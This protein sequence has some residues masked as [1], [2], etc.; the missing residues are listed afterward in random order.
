[1]KQFPCV[2]IA[3]FFFGCGGGNFVLFGGSGT[4]F[5]SPMV[6][7]VA[8]LLDGKYGGA[9]NGGDLKEAL[10]LTADDVGAEGTDNEFSH[11]RVNADSATDL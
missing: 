2:V 7:G 1:M 9:L 11:G 8:A 4:S 10:K 6:A 3:L 5:S